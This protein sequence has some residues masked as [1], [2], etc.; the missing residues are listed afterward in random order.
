MTPSRCKPLFSVLLL[1]ALPQEAMALRMRTGLWKRLHTAPYIS[2]RCDAGD[3]RLLLVQTGMGSRRSAEVFAWALSTAGCDLVVSFGFA[4]GL[5]AGLRVGDVCLCHRFGRWD[6]EKRSVA[7][8]GLATSHGPWATLL[9]KGLIPTPCLDVTTDRLTSKKEIA[10][11]LPSQ[12]R[13][14]PALV[15]MENF[16]WAGLARQASLPFLTLRSISD[17]LEHEL[18]FDLSCISDER[19]HIANRR[20]M[21]AVLRKPG[22]AVDFAKLWRAAGRAAASLGMTTAALVGLPLEILQIIA[23]HSRVTEWRLEPEPSVS[24]DFPCIP[25]DT[26]RAEFQEFRARSSE[27]SGS[28]RK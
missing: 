27:L 1:A 28:M 3:R 13:R 9:G 5:T 23:E 6:E 20:L 16:A 21:R 4:G 26:D 11:A 25:T 7:P 22:L 15:D 8:E 10:L 24:T 12:V 2:W 18:D 17:P 19:G 14:F